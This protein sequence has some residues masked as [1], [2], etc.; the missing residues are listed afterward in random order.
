[1][2]K[3]LAKTYWLNVFSG[4]GF[5]AGYATGAMWQ[6]PSDTVMFVY[7]TDYC[8]EKTANL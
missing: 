4:F 3:K 2:R 7:K 5:F 6:Y 1:V 8:E